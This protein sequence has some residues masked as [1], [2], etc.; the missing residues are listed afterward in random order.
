MNRIGLW[1]DGKTPATNTEQTGNRANY[2]LN[3]FNEVIL[4]I[5]KKRAEKAIS[6]HTE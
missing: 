2:L 5:I 6:L 1:K 4:E 3:D